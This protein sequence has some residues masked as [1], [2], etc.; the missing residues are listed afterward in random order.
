MA[1]KI[2]IIDDEPDVIMILKLRLQASGYVV[3]SAHDGASG[4]ARAEAE[5]PDLIVLDVKMPD[6]DGFEV[7]QRLQS[8]TVTAA[9]PVLF[10][11]AL[12]PDDTTQKALEL[13]ACGFVSKSADPEEIMAM[14]TQILE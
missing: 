9:I 11:S 7:F 4:Q 3:E 10:F 6:A 14:I 2:L 5:Q 8:S 1:Q 12:P 13:G